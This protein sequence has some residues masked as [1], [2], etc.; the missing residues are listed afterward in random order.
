MPTATR[1]C[2]RASGVTGNTAAAIHDALR[3]GHR[4]GRPVM[5]GAVRGT[6]IGYNIARRGRYLGS[7][8]PLLVETELGVAKCSLN[9]V[10]PFQPDAALL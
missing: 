10:R 3:S 4:I 6:V 5:V 9:E 1:D 2:L 8:F 7:R